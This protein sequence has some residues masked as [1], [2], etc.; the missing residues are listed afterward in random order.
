MGF[1]KVSGGTAVRKRGSFIACPLNVAASATFAF[2][3]FVAYG[4][5]FS[6]TPAYAFDATPDVSISDADSLYGSCD[7]DS[8]D[9]GI[10][11]FETGE[12]PDG[13]PVDQDVTYSYVK[14]VGSN[15]VTF[16]VYWDEP[17]LGTETHF[18]IVCSGG[19]SEAKVRMDAPYCYEVGRADED[20]KSVEGSAREEYQSYTTLSDGEADF[21]FTMVTSGTYQYRFYFTDHIRGIK[22]SLCAQF[23]ISLESASY[24]SAGVDSEPVVWPF[25]DVDSSVDHSDDINWLAASGISTGWLESDGARAFRPYADVT[26]ADMAAFLYRLAGSPEYTVPKVS[27]FGDVTSDM[28]HYKEICWLADRGISEGWGASGGR[29]FRPYSSIT[30][31]DMAAF[32]YRLASEL[33]YD[34]SG[35]PFIDCN[36]KTPHYEEVCWLASTG[37]SAGWGVPGGREF[38]PYSNVARAD[39]AAFLHRMRDKSLV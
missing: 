8:G 27:P 4:A 18:H 26:R 36:S 14:S 20:G 6:G 39:V 13:M 10:G 28:A 22:E 33:D 25:R 35:A 31:C 29:E 11:S 38:R 12:L 17:Q 3:L 1:S 9:C 37:V 2:M 23:S 19:S 16:T 30:R 24:P 21:T 15:G 7:L 5:L 34:V 32:L